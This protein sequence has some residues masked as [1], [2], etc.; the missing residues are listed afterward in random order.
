MAP[1]SVA[2]CKREAAKQLAA[3]HSGEW[4]GHSFV[5]DAAA[6][7]E[8]WQSVAAFLRAP[9]NVSGFEATVNSFFERALVLQEDFAAA[10]MMRKARDDE[11][12]DD[13]DRVRAQIQA[14]RA[15]LGEKDELLARHRTRLERWQ[16]EITAV[17]DQVEVAALGQVYSRDSRGAAGA[18]SGPD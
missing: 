14:L 1:I 18:S 4:A 13:E 16:A 6:L 15:E 2:A 5:A 17:E 12:P 9:T 7:R 8:D 3:S 10:R 11:L